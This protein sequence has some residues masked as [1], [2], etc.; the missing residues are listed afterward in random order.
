MIRDATLASSSRQRSRLSAMRPSFPRSSLDTENYACEI[1]PKQRSCLISSRW[2]RQT[3]TRERFQISFNMV[4]WNRSCLNSFRSIFSFFE[5]VSW[6]FF[7]G[8]SGYVALHWHLHLVHLV[9]FLVFYFFSVINTN[10][11]NSTQKSIIITC[12]QKNVFLINVSY[13]SMMFKCKC[14]ER[15]SDFS[16]RSKSRDRPRPRRQAV[17]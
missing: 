9:F 7:D 15:F 3:E 17:P 11:A 2:E 6:Y 16:S 4:N 12:N 10:H 1:L 5:F 8:D 14:E 13:A